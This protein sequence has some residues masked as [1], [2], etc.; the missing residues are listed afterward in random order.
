MGC[1]RTTPPS[2]PGRFPCATPFAPATSSRPITSC[3]C[4]PFSWAVTPPPG[5]LSMPT[6]HPWTPHHTLTQ[7]QPTLPRTAW[8]HPTPLPLPPPLT[9]GPRDWTPP[10]AC[11]TWV[12]Q[13]EPHTP[14]HRTCFG[15]PHTAP[16]L[17]LPHLPPHSLTPSPPHLPAG[18]HD[19]TLP[20]PAWHVPHTAHTHPLPPPHTHSH[21]TL[22][23]SHL[24]TLPS[25]GHSTHTPY[26]QHS[27]PTLTTPMCSHHLPIP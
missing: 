24:P 21:F 23:T 9:A 13:F 12:T 26:P 6:P 15:T 25:Y 7:A 11:H 17:A 4:F 22:H 19:T 2:P 27:T 14:P 16:M 18:P 3:H 8:L 20:C 1:G 5:T 10:P